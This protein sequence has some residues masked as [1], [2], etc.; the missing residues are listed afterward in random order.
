MPR[1]AHLPMP[2]LP[3]HRLTHAHATTDMYI[4]FYIVIEDDGARGIIYPLRLHIPAPTLR[5]PRRDS[6]IE[7]TPVQ[8]SLLAFV[9]LDSGCA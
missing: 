8:P 7:T 3:T 9:T 4:S 5:I 2:H 1:I 6:Y